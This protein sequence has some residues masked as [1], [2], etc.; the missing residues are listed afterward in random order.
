MSKDLSEKML[1]LKDLH[2][3]LT[4]RKSKYEGVLESAEKTREEIIK[5][6]R[7][8]NIDPTQLEQLIQEKEEEIEKEYKELEGSLNELKS[9]FD[10]IEEELQ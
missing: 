1:Q 8:K 6:L 7:D 2:H 9:K 10:R 4:E 3:Q 5:E